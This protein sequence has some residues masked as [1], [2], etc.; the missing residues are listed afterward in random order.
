MLSV[1]K[2]RRDE[3]E[4]ALVLA[5]AEKRRHDLRRQQDHY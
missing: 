5:K 1:I 3:Q 4:K 2:R